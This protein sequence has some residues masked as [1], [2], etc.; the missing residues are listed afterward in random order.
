MS[1][2]NVLITQAKARHRDNRTGFSGP[3]WTALLCLRHQC[4][5]SF[6][7]SERTLTNRSHEG[8]LIRRIGVPADNTPTRVVRRASCVRSM[9]PKRNSDTVSEAVKDKYHTF[10]VFP[11]LDDVIALGPG[12]LLRQGEPHS[13]G[14]ADH[15]SPHPV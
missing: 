3:Y 14:T 4:E 7:P 8:T 10:G 11:D 13:S 5:F 15:W 12:D 1:E 9:Q 6:S 2:P